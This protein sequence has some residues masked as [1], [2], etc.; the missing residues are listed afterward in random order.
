MCSLK[1]V[2]VFRRCTSYA[3]VLFLNL[4]SC[5]PLFFPTSPVGGESLEKDRKITRI[6]MDPLRCYVGGIENYK[7]DSQEVHAG[8]RRIKITHLEKEIDMTKI[9]A[10]EAILKHKVGL[11]E[12]RGEKVDL[13]K[14]TAEADKEGEKATRRLMRELSRELAKPTN[15]HDELYEPLEDG[16]DEDCDRVLQVHC[17]DLI[18]GINDDQMEEFFAD[19]LNELC[20]P[21]KSTPRLEDKALRVVMSV[22][23]DLVMMDAETSAM[24]GKFRL[25]AS[26]LLTH[27]QTDDVFETFMVPYGDERDLSNREYM[28][29]LE[30]TDSDEDG[31][32]ADEDN[33][34]AGLDPVDSDLSDQE[35]TSDEED[36]SDESDEDEGEKEGGE[37]STGNSESDSESNSDSDSSDVESVQDGDRVKKVMGE[38]EVEGDNTKGGSDHSDDSDSSDDDSDY[39]SSDSEWEEEGVGDS[40]FE[41]SDSDFSSDSDNDEGEGEGSDAG[42]ERVEKTP[43]K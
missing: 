14:L 19:A 9:D 28:K 33:D 1:R 34:D 37:I 20:P 38:G 11:A 5:I 17:S 26:D 18:S 41:S 6:A 43:L 10:V 27:Q 8:R 7:Y 21:L 23:I 24:I 4:H 35:F 39:D 40:D 2:C 12:S 16:E 29:L 3:G 30:D 32:E 36:S 31:S 42:K 25:K 13:E 22:G 15:P